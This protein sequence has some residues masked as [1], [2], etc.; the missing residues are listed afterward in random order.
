VSFNGV[1]EVGLLCSVCMLLF[2]LE[3]CL[4]VIIDY[5]VFVTN[6]SAFHIT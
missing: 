6:N 4:N 5:V 2:F 1:L 3:S